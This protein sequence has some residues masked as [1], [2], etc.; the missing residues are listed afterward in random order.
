ME[1]WILAFWFAVA[2]VALVVE[3]ETTELVSAWF[4]V[5]A[6]ITM[7]VAAIWP[8]EYIA[9]VSTFVLSSGLALVI[10]RPILTKKLKLNKTNDTDKINTMDGYKGFA[11][12]DIDEYGGKVNVNGTTW[13]ATSTSPINE[14]DRIKVVRES[15]LTLI[16]EKDK[17]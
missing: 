8:K 5:G 13:S 15:N 9:Q 6:F 11:E 17:E 2:I 3:I 7:I 4:I 1:Y 10:L 16:V 14:G 12:T